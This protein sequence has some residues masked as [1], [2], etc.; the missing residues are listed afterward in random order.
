[1]DAGRCLHGGDRAYEPGTT[2][3]VVIAVVNSRRFIID[4][5]GVRGIRHVVFDLERGGGERTR[6]KMGDAP[7]NDQ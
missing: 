6:Q 3:V 2:A 1:M 5:V 4:G 7:K